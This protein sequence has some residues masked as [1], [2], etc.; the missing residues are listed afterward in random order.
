VALTTEEQELFDLA[1]KT[2]PAWYADD[3]RANEYLGALAKMFGSARA[4]SEHWLKVVVY[5][6]LATVDLLSNPDWLDQHARDRG[7]SRQSGESDEALIARLRNIEDL[8]TREAL[9]AAVQTMMTAAGVAGAPVMV[10]MPRDRAHFGSY[11]SFGGAG[12][13]SLVKSGTDVLMTPAALPAAQF[14]RPPYSRRPDALSVYKITLAGCTHSANNGTFTT[15]GLVGG[16]VKF[17]NAAGVSETAPGGASWLVQRFDTA[18]N[19]RDGFKR[20]FLGRGYRMGH[21]PPSSFIV[22]LPY[23]TTAAFAA[24]V[25]EMLRTKKAGGVKATVERRLVP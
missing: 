19:L 11:S 24:S 14:S 10:E 7:T 21:C 18:G 4:I 3:Q 1:R 23:P 6:T 17:A 9:L 15:T 25:L 2:L 16:A 5:I 12:G 13:F 22:I 8:V 20:T